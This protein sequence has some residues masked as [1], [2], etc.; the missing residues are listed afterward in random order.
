MVGFS[1]R[2]ALFEAVAIRDTTVAADELSSAVVSIPA[3]PRGGALERMA[4]LPTDAAVVEQLRLD[5]DDEED[6]LAE[7]AVEAPG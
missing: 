6:D 1:S 5:A 2:S 3:R 7:P 4:M